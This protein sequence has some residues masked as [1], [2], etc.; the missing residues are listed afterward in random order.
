MEDKI[1]DLEGRNF[2][3][4]LSI[5]KRNE[6]KWAKEAYGIPLK[7]VKNNWGSRKEEGRG[8]KFIERNNRWKFQ[9]SGER[10]GYPSS[11]S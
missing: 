8:R 10:F 4:T 6:Q 1:N 9:K 3:I 5:K 7:N 11:W 2:E